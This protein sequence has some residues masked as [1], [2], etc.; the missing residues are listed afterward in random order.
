MFNCQ[1][2]DVLSQPQQLNLVRLPQSKS[3]QS[4]AI[5]FSCDKLLA[6]KDVPSQT[7]GCKNNLEP[8]KLAIVFNL[9]SNGDLFSH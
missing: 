4:G 1:I 7:C 6:C 9:R 2:P 8:E 5:P 3:T